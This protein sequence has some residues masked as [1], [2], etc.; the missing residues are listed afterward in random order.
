MLH[1]SGIPCTRSCEN[2]G[3]TL[4]LLREMLKGGL[5]FIA[6]ASKVHSILNDRTVRKILKL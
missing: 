5:F 6:L 3:I 1:N 4:R 2:V